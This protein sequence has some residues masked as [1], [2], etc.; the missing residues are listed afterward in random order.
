MQSPFGKTF[1]KPP[2]FPRRTGKRFF[3]TIWSIVKWVPPIAAAGRRNIF[4]TSLLGG[5]RVWGF[6]V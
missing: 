6:R 1:S 3:Q 4:V 2:A 5:V